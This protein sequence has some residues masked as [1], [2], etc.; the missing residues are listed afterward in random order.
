MAPQRGRVRQGMVV[1]VASD[2]SR[3]DATGTMSH[4]GGPWEDD[5]Q[6]TYERIDS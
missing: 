2:G 4:E 1:T 6:L 5:L 3:L